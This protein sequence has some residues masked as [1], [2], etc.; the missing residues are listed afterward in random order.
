MLQVVRFEADKP[1]QSFVNETDKN[2]NGWQMK[3]LHEKVRFN[4]LLNP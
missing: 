1:I 3:E 2:G 4:L